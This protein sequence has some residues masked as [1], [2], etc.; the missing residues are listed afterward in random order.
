MEKLFCTVSRASRALT[1]FDLP[2]LMPPS[3]L[4][5]VPTPNLVS[6]LSSL[7]LLLPRISLS[8]SFGTILFSFSSRSLSRVPASPFEGLLRVPS[9]SKVC[10]SRSASHLVSSS[11][12]GLLALAVS[13]L[14]HSVLF[15]PNSFVSGGIMLCLL[16]PRLILGLP[17]LSYIRFLCFCMPLRLLLL[18]VLCSTSHSSH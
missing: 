6:Y 15:L 5:R 3:A 17:F 4:A 18:I 7:S 10:D 13:F 16:C 12:L 8:A 1:R 2:R 14:R 11:R 9:N